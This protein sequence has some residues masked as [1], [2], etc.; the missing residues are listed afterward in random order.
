MDGRNTGRMGFSHAA[1][2]SAE[3][4]MAAVKAGKIR[5]HLM[6]NNSPIRY[7]TMEKREMT[8]YTDFVRTKLCYEI[9]NLPGEEY[10]RKN[11]HKLRRTSGRIFRG[12]NP[13]PLRC[14]LRRNR[15]ICQESRHPRE[16]SD[17]RVAVEPCSAGLFHRYFP[18]ETFSSG[19]AYQFIESD[20]L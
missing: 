9:L 2:D 10:N 15:G 1:E 17:Q 18:P 3:N 5:K 7:G 6:G 8:E 16:N 20:L 19:K 12:S 14:F 11:I 4:M 13:E